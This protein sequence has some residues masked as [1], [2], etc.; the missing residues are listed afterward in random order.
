MAKIQVVTVVA[1]ITKFLWRSMHTVPCC[2][3]SFG[4][5]MLKV[6]AFCEFKYGAVIS[7]LMG[8]ATVSLWAEI[9]LGG[10]CFCMLALGGSVYKRVKL[11]ITLGN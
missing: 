5:T 8:G 2:S 4:Y 6:S 7:V 11:T 3:Y 9:F 1:I 10:V